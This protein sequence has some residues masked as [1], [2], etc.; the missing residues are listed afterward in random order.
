VRTKKPCRDFK[1]SNSNTNKRRESGRNNSSCKSNRNRKEE[2]SNSRRA[3]RREARAVKK[4]TMT[5]TT[6]ESKAKT[7][8]PRHCHVER[9]VRYR[10]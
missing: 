4:G 3:S 8:S 6:V 1:R 5:M 7:I 9:R 2:S 10:R